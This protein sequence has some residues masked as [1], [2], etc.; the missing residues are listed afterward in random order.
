MSDFAKSLAGK[1]CIVTGA[2]QGIGRRIAHGFADAGAVPIIAE[3]NVEAGESVAAEIGG[4]RAHF[5]ETDVGD[6]AS[7]DAMAKNVLD[8][9]GR[10]DVLVNNAG[11]FSGLEMRPFW[12]IPIEEWTRV[13]HVNATGPFMASRAVL[14]A[15]MKAKSGRIIHMSSAAVTMG[16]P[17]YLHY[18][19]SKSALIGMTHSMAHELGDHGI[20][21]NAVMPGAVFT[22][23]ERKTVTPQQ[24]A[25]MVGVQSLHREGKPDDIVGAVLFLSSDASRW[26]TG[27]CL[28]V[29]GGLVHR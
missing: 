2:G 21:V 7:L 26:V 24:K 15:M 18:I 13:L 20:I 27:Q 16:R 5:V 19:A 23:I 4:N 17:N 14:P 28:T 1:V 3:R 29:D 11:I 6:M 22:E 25:A 12:Q 10:I 9:F 8:R